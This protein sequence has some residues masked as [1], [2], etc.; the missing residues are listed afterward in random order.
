MLERISVAISYLTVLDEIVLL[1]VI[2]SGNQIMNDS[3]R[4]TKHS[5]RRPN[6][7]LI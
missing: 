3:R 5:V 6:R 2:R 4:K 7:Y 1:K